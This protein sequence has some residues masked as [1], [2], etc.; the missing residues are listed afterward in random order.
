[1]FCQHLKNDWQKEKKAVL[2]LWRSNNS[3][4]SLKI[5]WEIIRDITSSKIIVAHV[6][7]KIITDQNYSAVY[8]Q[9][10]ESVWEMMIPLTAQTVQWGDSC[11]IPGSLLVSYPAVFWRKLARQM[12]RNF[13]SE[14][15]RLLSVTSHCCH[16][17]T[18]T[19]N[20]EPRLATWVAVLWY[21]VCQLR[22]RVH[23][24]VEFVEGSHWV[25]RNINSDSVTTIIRVEIPWW[26]FI[27]QQVVSF[28]QSTVQPLDNEYEN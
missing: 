26:V 17:G 16:S 23:G 15:S 13:M 24:C 14:S 21:P 19:S 4:Q 11:C 8:H 28:Q 12:K 1:V 27:R 25:G 3:L 20:P 7:A 5:W 18:G 9:N 22:R 2:E 6:T 10:T